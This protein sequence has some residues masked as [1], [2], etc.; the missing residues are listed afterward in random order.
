MPSGQ[1]NTRPERR[2]RETW[3]FGSYSQI[4][5]PVSFSTGQCC[6][7][8]WPPPLQE[9]RR[10]Q[11]RPRPEARPPVRVPLA[12]LPRR[13]PRPRPAPS[14]E[15]RTRRLPLDARRVARLALRRE[16]GHGPARQREAVGSPVE[17]G[18]ALEFH[19]G[20]P[21]QIPFNNLA[22]PPLRR[23]K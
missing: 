11:S 17:K 23:R 22:P 8:F 2:L 6:P 12:S 20:F 9:A 18:A 10:R 5:R 4:G 3:R 7:L 13:R 1:Q 14:H 15:P 21:L 16:P 19:Q